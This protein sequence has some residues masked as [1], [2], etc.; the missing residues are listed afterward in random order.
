MTLTS[1]CRS[2]RLP[3][4]IL[5]ALMPTLA[6]A[7]FLASGARA[8]AWPDGS[9][10]VSG[11]VAGA[12]PY[13]AAVGSQ[14]PDASADGRYAVFYSA[15]GGLDPSAPNGGIFRKNLQDDSAPI[16]AVAKLLPLA[17]GVQ[18]GVSSIA[19]ISATGRYVAFASGEN[20]LVPG[21]ANS[22]RDV[23]V[24]DMSKAPGDAG[25]YELVSAPDGTASGATYELATEAD[26]TA[27]TAAQSCL[28]GAVL[29]TGTGGAISNDGQRVLFTTNAFTNIAADSG[30]GTAPGNLFVRKRDGAPKQTVLVTRVN[31]DIGWNEDESDP[32]LDVGDPLPDAEY[33]DSAGDYNLRPLP[34]ASLSGD[35]S[36]VAWSGTMARVQ[37]EY[38][39]GENLDFTQSGGPFAYSPLYRRIDDGPAASTRRV[40]SYVDLDDPACNHSLPGFDPLFPP[41]TPAEK[42][43]A[44]PI[45]DDMDT[46]PGYVSAGDTPKLSNDGRRVYFRSDKQLRAELPRNA[47]QYDL[48]VSNMSPGVS[49]KAGLEVVTRAIG[50][51]SDP[52]GLSIDSVDV[53]GDGRRLAIKSQRRDFS[54]L[55]TEVTPFPLSTAMGTAFVIDRGNAASFASAD[56]EWVGRPTSG[57]DPSLPVGQALSLD[58]DGDTLLMT[59]PATNMFSGHN[60]QSHALC[61]RR[62]A[63]PC[64]ANV[65]GPAA[66]VVASPANG[67]ATADTTPQ[68]SGTAQAGAEVTVKLGGEVAC[69][70]TATGGGAWSCTLSALTEGLYQVT[71][72]A[73]ADFVTGAES[74]PVTFAVDLTAPSVSITAPSGGSTTT[75]DTPL[76]TFSVTEANPG[77]SEC[78]IDAGSWFACASG[79]SLA[80]L[81][82]GTHTL[83]VRH[84]DAAGNAGVSSVD[85]TVNAST[86]PPPPPPPPPPSGGTDPAAQVDVGVA[87]TSA[88]GSATIPVTV[89]KAGSIAAVGMAKL[90]KGKKLAKQKAG[91]ANA[92]AI[93]SG[94]VTL[95]FKL[96]A[97]A[98][99]YHKKKRKLVV[100]VT[101]TFT[102]V[103]GEQVAKTAKLTFKSTKKKK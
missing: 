40:T 25:A 39:L 99:K 92:T 46:D 36:S 66:P 91:V 32:A 78:R 93:G 96:N 18:C 84:T 27:I 12:S 14:N 86:P 87:K 63:A 5:L 15:D 59:S 17:S 10:L 70:D 55:L 3:A 19:S 101:L 68:V 43:C 21:D 56:I 79:D 16:E 54:N 9:A 95:T 98:K 20:G 89:N 103:V 74:G 75:D 11:W 45:E 22:R 6:I 38:H 81:A 48:Y 57:A 58:H 76:V 88:V 24:R 35:G 77:I 80:T 2:R 60:G 82:N 28:Y 83:D 65:S 41:G 97:A 100:D 94:T 33:F 71:A 4:S 53:S 31:Y 90:P 42:A 37:A 30:N 26:G 72:M 13:Q 23:F 50:Q 73:T 102:S 85:F 49:R 64:F 67:S 34:Y 69:T 44:G 61:V 29:P 8:T 7:L 62:G 1:P 51:L 52:G 47:F